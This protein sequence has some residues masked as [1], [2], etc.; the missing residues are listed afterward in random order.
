MAEEPGLVGKV[1]L[2]TQWLK[3]VWDGS[4]KGKWITATRLAG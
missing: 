4:K 2:V 1:G 3:C